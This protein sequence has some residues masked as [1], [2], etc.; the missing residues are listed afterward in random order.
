MGFFE[1]HDVPVLNELMKMRFAPATFTGVALS[2]E[3]FVSNA[4]ELDDAARVDRASGRCADWHGRRAV[5]HGDGR[6]RPWAF[7]GTSVAALAPI[8]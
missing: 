3:M 7:F 8:Q 2:W 6:L 1:W 5:G 4:L